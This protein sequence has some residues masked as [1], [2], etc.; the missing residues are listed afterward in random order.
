MD[1][2]VAWILL[3]IPFALF[4]LVGLQVL[5]SLWL[6]GRSPQTSPPVVPSIPAWCRLISGLCGV[7]TVIA[8]VCLVGSSLTD[9]APEEVAPET[10]ATL[11]AQAP[12][13]GLT[14]AWTF[15]PDRP[16][17]LMLAMVNLIGWLSCRFSLRY[18]AG[19]HRQVVYFSAFAWTIA[20]INTMVL[21]GS[22]IV[23]A[24]FWASI[25]LG[26]HQLLTHHR[27][28]PTAQRSAWL[29][30]GFSRCGD[31]LMLVA[32]VHCYVA[33]G[34]TNFSELADRVATLGPTQ[35]TIIS[36]LL[37]A[38]A[39]LK[40]AQFPFHAWLPLALATPTPVSA[41]MHAGVVNAGGFLLIRA[42]PLI[43]ISP[44]VLTGLTVVGS[45]TATVGALAMLTQPSIKKGLA[46]STVAQMGFMFI[47]CGLGM[48][49][50]VMLHL[51]A[52][53]L[54]KA[55]AFLSSGTV[56][57]SERQSARPEQRAPRVKVL[58]GLVG[59]TLI[60]LTCWLLLDKLQSGHTGIVFAWLLLLTMGRLV[61]WPQAM[62]KESFAQKLFA[63]G[64]LLGTFAI[65]FRLIHWFLP[66]SLGE[67]VTNVPPLASVIAG[68]C[69]T[70]LFMTEWAIGYWPT[71]PLL[72]RLYVASLND[73][74]LAKL[75][76]TW[77]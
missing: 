28:Q 75:Y 46:H 54:Y 5:F 62:R 3:T 27:E 1:Q 44:V 13:H 52:H 32:C 16:G 34:T 56:D 8:F 9:F 71:N 45:L 48:W 72:K 77:K 43:S 49:G 38:A 35:T 22:L 30:L 58:S 42:Y 41:L 59:A 11:M 29:K 66:E 2:Y 12:V 26:L 18:L 19:D 64:L 24:I 33:I 55:F 70:C 47:Q 14:A 15:L 50:A 23:F 61:W 20:S 4:G 21:S 6:K 39:A 65:C 25:S 60:V 73:F 10:A 7:Q 57:F 53:S 63:G 76:P 40:S 74:Y 36:V 31:L 51:V 67:P 68:T 17:L 37:A 69:L